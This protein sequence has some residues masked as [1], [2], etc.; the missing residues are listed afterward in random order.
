VKSLTSDTVAG[1]AQVSLLALEPASRFT[2]LA[3]R[4]VASSLSGLLSQIN[5]RPAY[6][7]HDR[8]AAIAV[9]TRMTMVRGWR[10]LVRALCVMALVFLNF[11]HAPHLAD[12]AV[13][14]AAAS[15]SGS[16]LCGD[17]PGGSGGPLH[18][19]CE[20]CRVG[21][22]ACMPQAGALV[23][24]FAGPVATL[25]AVPTIP[26]VHRHRVRVSGSRAPPIG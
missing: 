6:L 21:S 24:T 9:W 5:P 18:K 1:A 26:T 2:R 11:G 10:E 3:T 22:A 15:S 19:A 25:Q 7:P 23:P 16:S 17:P 12:H 14:A 4:T 8:D 13:A 20:A